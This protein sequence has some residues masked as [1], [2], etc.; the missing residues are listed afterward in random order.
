M[1]L[2]KDYLISIR[3]NIYFYLSVVNRWILVNI[4]LLVFSH[5]IPNLYCHQFPFHVILSVINHTG[6]DAHQGQPVKVNSLKINQDIII[7]S[8]PLHNID[9]YRIHD[10]KYREHNIKKKKTGIKMITYTLWI[11]FE[12]TK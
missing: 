2:F 9:D 8:S 12:I 5:R 7:A 6:K 11:H 3:R 1:F 4:I 10:Y